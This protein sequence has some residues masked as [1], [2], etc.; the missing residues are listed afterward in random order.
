M[1]KIVCDRCKKEIKTKKEESNIF[2]SFR[3]VFNRLMG[4]D[5]KEFNFAIGDKYLDDGKTFRL[6]PADIC[7]E[8]EKQ[9]VEWFLH[10][11]AE[12]YFHSEKGKKDGVSLRDLVIYEDDINGIPTAK[13]RPE[14]AEGD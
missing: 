6:V 5:E 3:H 2:W 8:C 10:P 13:N 11:D 14:T 9:F 1:K 12:W 7:P 4:N